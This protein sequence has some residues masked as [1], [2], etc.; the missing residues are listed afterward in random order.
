[1]KATVITIGDEILIGQIVDTNTVSIA[2]Q[3]NNVGI[4]IAEKL[5][6]GDDKQSIV[7][8]L[9]RAVRNSNVVIITGGL[10][11]TKD[12][13]TKHT[14]AQY[15]GSKLVYNEV[16]GEHVRG[17]LARRGIPFT[18]LNRGQAMLP[19]CCTVL[20]NAHGTAPGMW[21]DTP[22]GGVVVS[23]PGVPF[24]MEHL[25]QDIVIPMLKE[26]FELQS[27]VHRTLITR[28][29][30]ESI[31][32]ERISEWEDALPEYLH[33]AYLPSPNIVR[34]RLSA[35]GVDGEVA[36]GEISRQFEL[37]RSIIG[38]NIVG[39]EGATIEQLVHEIMTA[40][41]LKLAVAESC[42][43][44]TIASKFTAMP[45][46][47]SYFMAGVVSYS[48]EAKRDI[49]GVS[50][51]DI[52]TYGAVSEQVACQMAEGV[53][54]VAGADYAIATTGIAGP[55]GGSEAKPVGTV[56]IAVATPSKTFALMRNSG[57]DRGQII[58]RASAYAIE[59][60]YQELKGL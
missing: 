33:L 29:I 54:R 16:E 41:A 25:M 24:E 57:T 18:E 6:I 31:L 46:A 15:F 36:E 60:L 53:R 32:A 3:L 5:S 27:I 42:T 22:E 48:N 1:M 17:L 45:G 40:K 23:L 11:P 47:S 44:G 9:E 14:L 12:D 55:G 51:D 10:G 58:S 26:R 38:D 4:R 7:E 35:Y 20:H 50:M 39:F 28:G 13:I 19:E 2:R 37:L 30:P 43:G 49:L 34:L 8:T 21:F 52:I 56:W 59:M